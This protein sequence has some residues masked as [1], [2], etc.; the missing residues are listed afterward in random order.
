MGY[1]LYPTSGPITISTPG[2][3][4]LLKSL[5][6]RKAVGPD[7]V[8]TAMLK[9]YA[10]ILG[11]ILADVFQRSLDS[12]EIPQDWLNTNVACK[13]LEHTIF[14]SIMGHADHHNI[15]TPHQHGFRKG[16]SCESQ[17]LVC[18]SYH[19]YKCVHQ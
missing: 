19:I 13:T 17:L 15:I 4:K 8:P 14:S 18:I 16:H 7:L 9:E 2:V 5:N 1:S 11:P 12:G 10:E 6:Y 3:V